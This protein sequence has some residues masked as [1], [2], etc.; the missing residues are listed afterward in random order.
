MADLVLM[1][2]APGSG[3]TTWARKVISA[4]T[5]KYISRDE[6]RQSIVKEGEEFFS[7]ENEVIDTF[8]K[9]VD[10]ALL[11]TKRYVYVDA[12]HLTPKSRKQ[13]LNKLKN[14]Y[15][16]LYGVHI[17]VSCSTVQQ[18][19]AQ[20]TGNALVPYDVV[21]RMYNSYQKPTEIEGFDAVFEVG[22]DG[23]ILIDKTTV[24][25]KEELK[26]SFFQATRT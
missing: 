8:A 26:W 23:K 11:T 25:S 4:K 16:R 6:I 13:I 18:R 12:T 19:N 2:G 14:K 10:E 22:P 5:D 21:T 7:H 9:Q 20:R 15:E 17:D 3:K 24:Y 1:M